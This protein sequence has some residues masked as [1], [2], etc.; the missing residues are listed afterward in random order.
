MI[1]TLI[2]HLY[3]PRGRG[4]GNAGRGRGQG[5]GR[6][7][8]YQGNRQTISRNNS[9]FHLSEL[10][11]LCSMD[12]RQL[13]QVLP[14]RMDLLEEELDSVSVS[15]LLEILTKVCTASSK[16]PSLLD[17]IGN[18]TFM[19]RTLRSAFLPYNH[20]YQGQRLLFHNKR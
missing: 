17:S 4:R 19:T 9:R 18:S 15:L 8:G 6:R 3:V 13:A 1:I 16:D 11:R 7:G 5:R 10:E 14:G 12:S 2:N 20:F